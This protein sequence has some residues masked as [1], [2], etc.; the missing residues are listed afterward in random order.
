MNSYIFTSI[1]NKSLNEISKSHDFVPVET[2]E[3]RLSAD[4][5]E[6]W[7][8]KEERIIEMEKVIATMNPRTRYILEQFYYQHRSYKEVAEEL[9]ITTEGIKK[10]LVKAMMLFREHFNINKHKK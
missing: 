6:E 2:S 8:Q 7:L 4:S 5:G 9:G 1:R 10:Q 3:A